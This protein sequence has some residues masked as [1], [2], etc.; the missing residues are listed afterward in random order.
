MLRHRR[1]GSAENLCRTTARWGDSLEVR[2][3]NFETP[4]ARGR[5]S[6]FQNICCS[7]PGEARYGDWMETLLYN[8]IGAALPITTGGRNF[9]YS[10]YALG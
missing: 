3:D 7:S 4:A 2:I 1:Y 6:N 9:Y 8:G 10:S 5:A